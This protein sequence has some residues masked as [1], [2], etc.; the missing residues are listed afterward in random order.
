MQLSK[1]DRYYCCALLGELEAVGIVVIL[2]EITC[3]SF[4]PLH[5]I[6]K[7]CFLKT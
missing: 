1:H 4:Q 2:I 5:Y 3:S 7:G 6:E